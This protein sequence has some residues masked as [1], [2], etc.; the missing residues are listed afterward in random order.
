MLKMD[1][2]KWYYIAYNLAR[3]EKNSKSRP[4]V[5]SLRLAAT[6]RPKID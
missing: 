4:Y 3:Y 2:F 1:Y 5:E 6:M